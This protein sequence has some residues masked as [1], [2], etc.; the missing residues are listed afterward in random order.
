[1]PTEENIV[2]VPTALA[3]ETL[4]LDF[5]LA[6]RPDDIHALSRVLSLIQP[7]MCFY[8]SQLSAVFNE[9]VRIPLHRHYPLLNSMRS[10]EEAVRKLGPD[11]DLKVEARSGLWSSRVNLDL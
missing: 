4:N 11:L 10:A 6:V 5:R 9:E 8:P 1:M 3:W 7:Q 2:T